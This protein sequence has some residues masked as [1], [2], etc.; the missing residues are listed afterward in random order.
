MQ[1]AEDFFETSN[2]VEEEV[3]PSLKIYKVGGTKN[4]ETSR[5]IVID[6]KV[7]SSLLNTLKGHLRK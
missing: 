2:G 5:T 1:N 4:I 6:L 3:E 7:G